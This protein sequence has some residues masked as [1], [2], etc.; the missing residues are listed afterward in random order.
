MA[1]EKRFGLIGI[2]YW[3]KN[4]LR[5]LHEMG[6]LHS[7]CDKSQTAL[8]NCRAQYPDAEFF[9]GPEAI[10]GNPDVRAVFIAAPAPSHHA[11][12]KE[13]ILAGK[14]VF[15]EKPLALSIAEGADLVETAA[16]LGRVL[17]VGHILRYHPGFAKLREL[18]TSG[19]LGTVNYIYSNRL[20]LGRFRT[21]ED[22]W[23]SFA[24]H[25]ISA[26]L[27]LA[28]REPSGISSFGAQFLTKG[29]ADTF[30][31]SLDFGE[32]LKGHVFVSWL[33][34]FKEQKLVV[35]GDRGMAVFCDSAPDK[36]LLLY[37]HRVSVEKGFPVAAKGEPEPVPF[38][39]AEPLR[40]ELSHFIHCVETRQRP[41]TDGEEGLRVLRVLEAAALYNKNGKNGK[42]GGNPAASASV[43]Q[44]AGDHPAYNTQTE[45]SASIDPTSR[46]DENTSIG[47]NTRIWH[48]SHVLSGCRIGANCVIGQNVM[49]GPDVE[50][51]DGC[52]IQNNVSLYKGVQLEDGVFCGPS[53][54]FT[55]V[56]NPRA[57]I[58][59]KSEFLPTLVKRG[60][61]I[62]AN[63]TI[64]CGITIGQYALIGAGA[65]VKKDVPPYAL[66]V[67]VPARRVGWVC[68]C[69]KTLK[70]Q[71]TAGNTEH[72]AMEKEKEKEK[73]LARCSC[74]NLYLISKENLTP[75]EENQ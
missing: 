63:A 29:V 10:I 13:A 36:K 67:G 48:F 53:C 39:K 55:N 11:L 62:G 4:I 43:Y 30:V 75:L 57:F 16:K 34:P 70:A 24:P 38:E 54:V 41:V 23:W 74:G 20:S 21:E 42:N 52:K 50:V 69:G 45:I 60:A 17:M 3:G 7:A 51:G 5:N 6:A 33:N 32:G 56:Y 22:I 35:A 15:V 72:G 18:A 9:S 73:M 44:A 61:T 1:I 14:D 19:A 8:E 46:V 58:N 2:G 31:A 65:V 71:Q 47:D 25:D 12:A 37:P 27:A 68:K 59:R 28:G 40:L 64:V 26:M 66:M 49:I